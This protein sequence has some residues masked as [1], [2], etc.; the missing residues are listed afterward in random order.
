MSTMKEIAFPSIADTKYNY[1]LI[2]SSLKGYF[3]NQIQKIVG[4]A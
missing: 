2:I 3:K 4:A 1:D